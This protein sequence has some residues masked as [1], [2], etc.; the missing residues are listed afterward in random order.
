MPTF[1]SPIV[2]LG[3]PASKAHNEFLAKTKLP[4]LKM[5][6]LFVESIMM[7]QLKGISVSYILLG[8]AGLAALLS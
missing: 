7:P 5:F 4:A 1:L 8:L 3:L 6:S 2:A